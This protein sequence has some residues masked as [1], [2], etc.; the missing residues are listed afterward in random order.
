[1]K[2]TIMC[3]CGKLAIQCEEASK[4]LQFIVNNAKKEVFDEFD[5]LKHTGLMY[6]IAVSDYNA[7]KRRHL[8][9]FPKEKEVKKWDKKKILA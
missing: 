1:M 6:C 2:H 7:M 5:R 9:T 4:A 3:K 8:S